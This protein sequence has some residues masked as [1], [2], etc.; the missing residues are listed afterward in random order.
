M[1][2]TRITTSAGS[3]I[4]IPDATVVSVDELDDA[5]NPVVA[6]PTLEGLAAQA[7]DFDA[8]LAAV[9]DAL[10]GTAKQATAAF[11]QVRAQV[12]ARA[13]ELCAEA[14]ELPEPVTAPV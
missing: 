4:D 13:A 6:P 10:V 8:R 3:V 1:S 7:D 9:E 11:E 12:R 5:G 14:I 2:L